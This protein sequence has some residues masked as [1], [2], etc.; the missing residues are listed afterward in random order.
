[1]N[2]ALM[3]QKFVKY[4]ILDQFVNG[5]SGSVLKR[6]PVDIFIDIQS[7]Y[8]RILSETLLINDVKVLSV[9]ILNLAGHYRHFF[10]SRYNVNTRIYIVNAFAA[11]ENIFE[12]LNAMNSDMFTIVKK[13]APYFPEV[14]YIERSNH[15]S[16][17]S[18][19]IFSLIKSESIP[20]NHSSIVISNDVYS[21]QIPAFIPS[22]FVIRPSIN[23]KFITF[24]NVIDMMYPRKG[25]TVTSDLNPGLLPLI[26]AHHK[27]SELGMTMIDNF[28]NTI[29]L[30][31][32]MINKGQILNGYNSPVVLKLIESEDIFKRICICDLIFNTT[33][34]ENSYEALVNNWTVH[35][36]CDYNSLANILDK[37]FNVD[38]E[39]I[40]NYLFLLEVDG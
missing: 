31:R 21:Y 32:E 26:M 37:A 22:S 16:K 14:Y 8:K 9:N 20:M 15:Y 28:K 12:Q 30:I 13:I 7:V 39:N 18:S 33:M 40:L 27:C 11:S 34:Y 1:M 17:A 10:K 3:F 25:S 4:N 35:K 29:K 38:E 23:T 5:H 6:T 36:Q 24:T 19:V 2:K